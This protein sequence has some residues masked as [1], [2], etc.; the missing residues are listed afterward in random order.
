MA[1]DDDPPPLGPEEA[2]ALRRRQRV[3]NWVLLL[4]LIGLVLLF[5]AIAIVKMRLPAPV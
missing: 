1:L 2:T 3:K 4:I 5:Y